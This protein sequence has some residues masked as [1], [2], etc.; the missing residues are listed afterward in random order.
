MI[1]TQLLVFDLDGTLL[2]HTHHIP[3]PVLSLISRLQA[4]G[5][6]VTI[7]TGRIPA[8]AA[9][10]LLQL[11]VDTPAIF[12]NGGLIVSST[13]ENIYKCTLD[14]E[15]ARDALLL[16]REFPVYPQLYLDPSDTFY[17]VETVTA[18]LQAFNQQNKIPAQEVGDLVACLDRAQVDPMKLL[19]IGDQD[20]LRQLRECYRRKHPEPTCVNSQHNYLEILPPNVSKGTALRRLCRLL[21]IDIEKVIA[22]GD[23]SN[24]RE[25]LLLAG[26]GVTMATAPKEM[27][28]EADYVVEDLAVYLEV[29]T[30]NFTEK[31]IYV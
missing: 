25:M 7:A 19:I 6:V 17:Y 16:A 20:V 10:F 18:S 21:E 26:T 28:D 29:L 4:H 2:D 8:S 27:L 12:Y 22:F 11:K 15:A 3:L 24:D 30:A 31:E 13:G 9:P 14:R 23:N 1:K 5:C